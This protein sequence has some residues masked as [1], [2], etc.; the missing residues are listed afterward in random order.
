MLEPLSE[1]D[2]PAL[3][4]IERLP[5]Y[6]EFVGR[7]PL[8]EHRA[9]FARPTARYFAWRDGERL[10]GFV[11]LQTFGEPIVRLRR[12]AVAEP[13]GG[14]GSALFRAVVDWVFETTDAT[15]VDLHVRPHNAR[16]IHLYQREGFVP[17]GR[18]D[19]LGEGLILSRE[20]WAALPWR[21]R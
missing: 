15:A 1:A 14:V 9:E 20:A 19:L 7:W 13:G 18:E 12:I 6:D 3:M 5:G 21:A 11:I 4:R 8:E 17:G 16:A 10:L 2:F